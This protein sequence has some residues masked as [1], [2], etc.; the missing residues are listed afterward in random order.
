MKVHGIELIEAQVYEGTRHVE[1]RREDY[2]EVQIRMY[3]GNA[4]D[5][6]SPIPVF[7]EATITIPKEKI[8][9]LIK[10]ESIKL[11]KDERVVFP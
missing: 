8:I 2:Q 5:D 7:E 3:T 9:Q 10:G 6:G 4:I 1:D 11:D